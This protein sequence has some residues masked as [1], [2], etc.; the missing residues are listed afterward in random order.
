MKLFPKAI[1]IAAKDP[2]FQG[3]PPQELNRMIDI[4]VEVNYTIR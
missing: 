3:H 4:A 1:A 2:K